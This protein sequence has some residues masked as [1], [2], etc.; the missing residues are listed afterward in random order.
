M[1]CRSHYVRQNRPHSIRAV[2]A[3]AAFSFLAC[4]AFAHFPH[5]MGAWTMYVA[6]R[7]RARMCAW[8]HMYVWHRICLQAR[9]QPIAKAVDA[10]GPLRRA[11][12]EAFLRCSLWLSCAAQSLLQ[13]KPTRAVPFGRSAF[14]NIA[15]C[16]VDNAEP[17]ALAPLLCICAFPSSVNIAAFRTAHR[18]ERE[19][20]SPAGLNEATLEYF[21]A[22]S[23]PELR[24]PTVDIAVEV[25][26][27][28]HLRLYSDRD[29]TPVAS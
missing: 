10:I 24:C 14:R 12:G 20:S 8:H 1:R 5:V 27:A 16:P 17:S 23:D 2:A 6:R 28:A 3:V 15:H 29:Y 19:G 21:A 4:R 22:A 18:F 26:A 7:A 9:S 13:T 25:C 11:T